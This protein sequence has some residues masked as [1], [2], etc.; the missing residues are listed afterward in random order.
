[1]YNNRA[2]S[3]LDEDDPLDLD[4]ENKSKKGRKKKVSNEDKEWESD[5]F[6]IIQYGSIET[7]SPGSGGK[8]SRGPELKPEY[9]NGAINFLNNL[10]RTAAWDPPKRCVNQPNPETAANFFVHIPH[11]ETE[12]YLPISKYSVEFRTQVE[13]FKRT[14]SFY[15]AGRHQEPVG[16]MESEFRRLKCFTGDVVD[17]AEGNLVFNCGGPVLGLSWHPSGKLIAVSTGKDIMEDLNYKVKT[18]RRFNVQIYSHFYSKKAASESEPES[19]INSLTLKLII[20]GEYGYA[21]N[22]QWNSF[23]PEVWD[24]YDSAEAKFPNV[25]KDSDA[26]IGQLT[27]SHEDGTIRIY[28][29]SVKDFYFGNEVDSDLSFHSQ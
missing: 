28:N 14:G 2:L 12:D 5:T 25:M 1:M 6:E 10:R 4:D 29:I 16:M 7:I 20:C 13:L 19:V 22:I 24:K 8:M 21:T 11:E 27:C 15:K 18:E 23:H 26:V 9:A 17:N 3:F